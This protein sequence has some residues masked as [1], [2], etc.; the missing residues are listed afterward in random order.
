MRIVMR[1]LPC[2]SR[3]GRRNP[4]AFSAREVI[5]LLH[6]FSSY[7]FRS[8]RS[9]YAAPRLSECCQRASNRQQPARAQGRRFRSRRNVAHPGRSR[10]PGIVKA[11]SSSK[12]GNASENRAPCFSKLLSAFSTSHSNAIF[13]HCMYTLC[14]N[15]NRLQSHGSSGMAAHVPM[16]RP[17][18]SLFPC[19]GFPC[20]YISSAEGP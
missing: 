17:P 8:L 20:F 15:A 18:S 11:W 19:P 2:C 4:S 3:S 5:F 12:T 14:T 7:C 9:S 16:R 1:V 13:P 6:R 10:R